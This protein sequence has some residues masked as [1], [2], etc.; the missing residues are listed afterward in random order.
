[1]NCPQSQV[2]ERGLRAQAFCFLSVY[3]CV[4]PCT[5]ICVLYSKIFYPL[6]FFFKRTKQN[7]KKTQG[8]KKKKRVEQKNRA[9]LYI[10][11]NQFLKNI[12]LLDYEILQASNCEFEEIE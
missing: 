11:D 1:M 6:L 8:T 4:C 12:Q 10:H 2:E 3:V 9:V 5:P 7:T